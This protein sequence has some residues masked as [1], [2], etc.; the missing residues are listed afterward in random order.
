MASIRAKRSATG[1][2]IVMN[3]SHRLRSF[4][5]RVSESRKVNIARADV[6]SSCSGVE[7]LIAEP[8][9]QRS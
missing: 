3:K 6:R 8:S 5:S 4:N 1:S 7:T 9:P 2:S